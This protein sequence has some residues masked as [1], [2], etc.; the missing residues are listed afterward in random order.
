MLTKIRLLGYAL[1]GQTPTNL[2]NFNSMLLASMKHVRLT[3]P[4]DLSDSRKPP[5]SRRIEDS[6]PISL[7]PRTLVIRNGAMAPT[8]PVD[9]A[10]HG[11]SGL[12]SRSTTKAEPRPEL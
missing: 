3:S 12:G 1:L 10:P 6:V 11:N 8:S 7:K 2:R 4:H 5:E 9:E